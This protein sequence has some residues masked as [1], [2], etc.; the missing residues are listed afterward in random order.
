MPHQQFRSS[1]EWKKHKPKNIQ[2]S[3]SSDIHRR[4]RKN[5]IFSIIKYIFTS[6]FQ[7]GKATFS[8]LDKKELFKKVATVGVIGAMFGSLLVVAL[9]GFYSR[10]LPDVHSILTRYVAES[11]KIYDRTGEELLYEIHGDEKRTIVELDNISPEV[12]DA[13]ISVEDES[14]YHHNGCCSLGIIR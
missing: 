2:R 1:Q 9:F 14:F 3:S 8:K 7:G 12:I 6:P 10:Q 5:S 11:T 4:P 13:L